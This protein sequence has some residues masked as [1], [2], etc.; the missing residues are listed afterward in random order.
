MISHV[1]TLITSNAMLMTY[2]VKKFEEKFEKIE[3]QEKKRILLQKEIQSIRRAEA[4][5]P[6]RPGKARLQLHQ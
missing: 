1:K 2:L 3:M 5:P 4:R 6:Q